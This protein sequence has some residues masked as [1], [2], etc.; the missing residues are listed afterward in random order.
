MR[1]PLLLLLDDA[2]DVGHIVGYLC[3][4]A[5][6]DLI[7]REDAVSALDFLR[8]ASPLPDLLLLDVNLPGRNGFDFLRDL[9]KEGLLDRIP[10]ALFTQITVSDDVVRALDVGIDFI[11]AKDALA[12]PDAWKERIEE[13]LTSARCAPVVVGAS[14]DTAAAAAAIHAVLQHP[15]VLRFGADVAQAVWR[16]AV[17]RAVSAKEPAA[18]L[19]SID[20]SGASVA[21]MQTLARILR[22]YSD[23]AI[24]LIASLQHQVEC[25]LGSRAARSAIAPLVQF[26][27]HSASRAP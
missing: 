2:P 16:R 17:R 27:S 7:V 9:R 13:I 5:G 12:R 20:L 6:Q 26:E 18:S 14:V 1:R 3:R 24:P 22:V 19:A 10:I 15:T 11:L 25:L 8:Q 21:T 23:C 4:R